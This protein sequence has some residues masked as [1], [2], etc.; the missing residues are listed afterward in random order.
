MNSGYSQQRENAP[1]LP[2]AAGK[3]RNK[4]ELKQR[5]KLAGA[6]ALP[7][8]LILGTQKGG[9]SSLFLYL[10]GHPQVQPPMVKEVHF[11][12]LKFSK[13]EAWYRAHFPR[14]EALQQ[15]SQTLGKPVITG[16]ASPYYLFHPLA[17]RRIAQLL[18]GVK[19]IALLRD[20]VERAFSHYMHNRQEK[21]R[22]KNREPLSFADAIA[23]EP[24]RLRGEMEKIIADGEYQSFAH[25]HYSYAARGVYIDQLRE[26]QKYFPAEN[27]LI[28]Q[29]EVFFENTAE[30]YQTVLDFLGLWPCMPPAFTARNRGSYHEK[31]AVEEA[32]IQQTKSKLRDYFRPFNQQLYDHLGRD[33]RW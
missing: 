12:D 30:T 5:M 24:E 25:Q 17:A 21:H 29:S 9:T 20:P 19:L 4:Q 10:A 31:K 33:F 6:H 16:E 23:A 14:Q 26:Y 11:F 1:L 28:L 18:P 2:P 15:Q 13:G 32:T 3:K 27:L 8:F 7:D 22:E